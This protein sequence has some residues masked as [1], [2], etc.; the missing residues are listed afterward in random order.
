MTTNSSVLTNK[1][2]QFIKFS[3]AVS[4]LALILFSCQKGPSTSDKIDTSLIACYPFD[5]DA[6]DAS[7]NEY[8]GTIYGAVLAEDRL[9]NS[10]SAYLFDGDDDYIELSNSPEMKPDFPFSISLWV[11]INAKSEI[12][13]IL[14]GSDNSS[15]IYSG[16]WL[17]Y[18]P[19]GQVSAGYGDGER[20]LSSWNRVT[21]HSNQALEINEWYN[22]SASFN[23]PNDIDLYIN[24]EEEIGYYS[25]SGGNMVDLG[26][27][28]S[29]GVR[30]AS[31]H[32]GLID[33]ILLYNRALSKTDILELC[34]D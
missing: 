19:S 24:C 13:S 31:Y 2:V 32:D 1:Q 21:K 3:V 9:G 18:L 30:S 6:K 4:S 22:I 10:N 5:G 12:A 28:G 15:S 20:G 23:G 16:F 7:I 8:H 27:I 26:L 11:K 14:Y 25:G 33:D 17:G 34:T 29:I